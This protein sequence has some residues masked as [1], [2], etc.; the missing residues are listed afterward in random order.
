[1]SLPVTS[2][3]HAEPFVLLVDDERHVTE[4][5]G[6]RLGSAGCRV[7]SACDGQA[8]LETARR[9]RP[10]LIITDLDMPRMTGLEL[11]LAVQADPQ[12]KGVP[13]LLLS[14]R[15]FTVSHADLEAANIRRVIEKPFSARKVVE[16][17][18]SALGLEGKAAA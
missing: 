1:M 14:A 17:A 9:A 5:V 10:N 8:A 11:A 6:R 4:I 3:E 15:G 18:L 2:W 13:V 12:L 7:Q 16:A